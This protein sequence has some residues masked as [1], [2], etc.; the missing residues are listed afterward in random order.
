MKIKTNDGNY[1]LKAKELDS[2]Y[3]DLNL[4]I[5]DH[6]IK[7]LQ[8][9]GTQDLISNPYIWQLEKLNDMHLLTEDVVKSIAKRSGV[10]EDVFRDVIANEGYKIYL[11]S[12]EQLKKALESNSLPDP[13]VQKSL[14]ALVDQTMYDLNNMINTTL[15]MNVRKNYEQLLTNAVA[16]VVTGSKSSEKALNDSVLK[17]YERGF[18]GFVDRGGRHWSVDRYA[19]T[20]LKTTVRRTYRE[21]REKPAEELGIDT[22]YYSSKSSARELCA[23]L[24]HQIVT[25]G[26]ARTIKGE[27]VLSLSDYGY[28]SPG[29]CLGINCGHYLTPFV[30]GVNEK[31]D[32]PESNNLSE[33]EL[34]ENALAQA[35]QR[36]YE[37]EIRKSKEIIYI[38]KQLEDKEVVE[39]HKVRLKNLNMGYKHLL[40]NNKHLIYDSSRVKF[41]YKNLTYS[42]IDDN[43]QYRKTTAIRFSSEKEV[44]ERR[45]NNKHTSF[46]AIRISTSKHK[47]LYVSKNVKNKKSAVRFFDNQLASVF[48]NLHVDIT[49]L[50][51]PKVV[52]VSPKESSKH[53]VA[54]YLPKDNALYVRSDLI[55]KKAILGMQNMRGKNY[56][57]ESNE[58][59]SSLV[60][61][62][63]HWYQLHSKIK[64]YPN[65][66][67]G[68]IRD[69][70]R[71]ESKKLIDSLTSKGYNIGVDI[72]KYAK[73]NSFEKPEEVF[74]EKFVINYYKIRR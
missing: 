16:G 64:E 13:L 38:A 67:N 4:E 26:V 10:T 39:K 23:P 42:D 70:I 14:N 63:A 74:A 5:M 25:K 60:H 28:G 50:E 69:L 52:I 20:V 21:L 40:E 51:K 12:H 17:L 43:A 66:T 32:L 59:N 62:L 3:Q 47:N 68:E 1:F 57:A 73:E 11:D 55:T 58:M 29:G 35:K 2:I 54:S 49:G 71:Y 19:R 7:R 15:P 37:R 9:R 45:V 8:S 53:V 61:E 48:E 56:F 31:P 27:K 24:Q 33:E 44:F 18:T 34:R 72:S 41:R 30:I 6:I 22:F 36:A 65:K 46:E